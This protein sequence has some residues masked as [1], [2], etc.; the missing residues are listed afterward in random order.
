MS[1]SFGIDPIVNGNSVTGTTSADIRQIFGAMFNQNQG[2]IQGAKV[3]TNNNRTYSIS[4]GLV[5]NYIDAPVNGH[6]LTPVYAAT[7]NAPTA[8]ASSGATHYIYV[9]QNI[10]SVDGNNKISYGVSTSAI[11][12]GDPRL[13]IA[14]FKVKQNY[15]K[16]SEATKLDDGNLPDPIWPVGTVGYI[17]DTTNNTLAA[18]ATKSTSLVCQLPQGP[19][20]S[21]NVDINLAARVTAT[22]PAESLYVY[23]YVNNIQKAIFSTGT[24]STVG[25]TYN[26]S[27]RGTGGGKTTIKLEY[28]SKP[29]SG[30]PSAAFNKSS[31]IQ[32]LSNSIGWSGTT[33]HVTDQGT[34]Y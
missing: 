27:W 31:K 6:V 22:S 1:T 28:W 21:F 12:P 5:L 34:V 25:Q 7:V 29:N 16:T 23:L 18:R 13:V 8:T 3:T 33:I 19:N 4:S 15:T 10:P 9:R 11:A 20:R 24:L 14:T 17:R 26:W 30:N 32:F 2:V